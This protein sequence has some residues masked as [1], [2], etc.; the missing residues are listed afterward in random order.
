LNESA[1]NGGSLVDAHCH[2]DLYSDLE[3]IVSETEA[4]HIYTIAVTNAPSVFFHTAE[5]TAG[6]KYVRPALGLHPELVSSHG[7]ELSHMR[8]LLKETRYVGEVGLDY[9]TSDLGLRKAQREVL[10]CILEWCADYGDKILT[11]HSRRAASDV[12]AMVGDG[13]PGKAILHWFSGSRKELDQASRIGLY[14]SVNPAM[15]R[16]EKGRSLVTLMPSDRVLTETDGPFVKIGK[17]LAEPADVQD[18]VK[19]LASIWNLPVE[20]ARERVLKNFGTMLR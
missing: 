5:F 9:Q 17:R 10:S 20:R 6:R 1:I 7:H 4:K 19:E 18:V 3:R 14:F 11:L 8:D 13:F 12:T 2:L 16:S 15:M